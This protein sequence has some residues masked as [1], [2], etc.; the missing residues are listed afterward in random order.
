[1]TFLR[2]MVLHL[3]CY[4][5]ILVLMVVF[6][7]GSVAPQAWVDDDGNYHVNNVPTC[8]EYETKQVMKND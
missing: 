2:Y 4:L 1:M 6:L 8:V 3:T 7:V 5:Q